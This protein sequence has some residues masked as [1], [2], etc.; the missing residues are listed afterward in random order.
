M[1][2]QTQ[3]HDAEWLLQRELIIND[4]QMQRGRRGVDTTRMP[5]VA[6]AY[7]TP[8]EEAAAARVITRVAAAVGASPAEL[9]QVL[10]ALGLTHT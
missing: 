4:A 2:T 3:R 5:S 9:D 8:A 7:T 6:V 1:I 10:D